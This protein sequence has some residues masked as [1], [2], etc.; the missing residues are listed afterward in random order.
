VL[1]M[2]G[3]EVAM[4]FAAKAGSTRYPAPAAGTV[5]A[6]KTMIKRTNDWG[7]TPNSSPLTQRRMSN[8]FGTPNSGC[9]SYAR[10]A[11]AIELAPAARCR[12]RSVPY[13]IGRAKAA[14]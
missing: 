3:R 8:I 1:L 4:I 5:A 14:N 6:T 10:Q 11:H 7:S 12:P 9:F 2:G 13:E